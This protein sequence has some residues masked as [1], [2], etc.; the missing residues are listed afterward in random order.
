M[1]GLVQ[2]SCLGARQ[3]QQQLVLYDDE[4]RTY[5]DSRSTQHEEPRN[6]AK[7]GTPRDAVIVLQAPLKP[8]VK[9][10]CG[11]DIQVQGIL[12]AV[13]SSQFPVI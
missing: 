4:P 12:L 8:L 3:Q 1:Q 2:L 7:L 6:V 10:C 5:Y 11:D 13:S 9:L